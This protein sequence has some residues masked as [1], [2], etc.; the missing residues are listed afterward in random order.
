MGTVELCRLLDSGL[1]QHRMLTLDLPYWQGKLMPVEHLD[2][3]VFHDHRRAIVVAVMAMCLDWIYHIGHVHLHDWKNRGYVPHQFSRCQSGFLWHM[4]LAMASLQQGCNGLRTSMNSRHCGPLHMLISRIDLVRSPSVDWRLVRAE[5]P[6]LSRT[7]D[8]VGQCVTLMLRSI[9]PSYNDVP[10]GLPESSGT[11]TRDFVSFFL[12]WF[13]SLPA[14]WFPVHKIRHLFTVKAYYVPCAG[15]A[16]FIWAV[17]KA[18]GIGPIVHQPNTIYGSDLAWGMVKGIMS[19]IANF[20]TLIVNDP[21]FARFA[22]KPKD[23]LWSQL[24]TI[25]IGFAVTSFIGIIV[26]SSSTVIF[27]NPIWN[28][29]DLLGMFLDG[30]SSGQR[31]GVFMISS[32]FA[33]AQ[34]GTNI[35]ANSV[36]AGTDMTALLP[37]WLNIRR[38]SYICAAVGLAMCPW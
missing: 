37:R 8:G 13:C 29:L 7:D 5:E 12:F 10:N 2:D 33:L 38:G 21:D 32:A 6:C 30:A 16:Y 23:A 27:G 36:S 25:P 31:F 15:V 24:F 11:S 35:A 20:A 18:H 26:S 19:S 4:G 17:T 22:R 14:L 3:I 9:W 1:I 28:P 34:L